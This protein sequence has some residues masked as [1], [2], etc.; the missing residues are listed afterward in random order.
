LLHKKLSWSSIVTLVSFLSACI[1]PQIAAFTPTPSPTAQNG[2][3]GSEWESIAPGLERRNYRPGSDYALTQFT[4]LRIDPNLYT[5]R[6]HYRPGEPLNAFAWRDALPDAAA[7]INANFFD[8]EGRVLGLLVS[9]GA[10]Y[11][12]AYQNMGG[13]LYVQDGVVRVRSTILEPYQGEVLEQATQAFPMLISDGEA[14]FDNTRGDRIS[15]RTI[16]AQDSEGQI[17]LM[18][19]S[20][21]IGIRLVDL[22]DYLAATDLDLVNAFNLDGGGSTMMLVKSESAGTTLIP[23]LDSVPAVLAIYPR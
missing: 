8:R 22:S 13:M 9:D 23:S 10:V 20:S 18:A 7:F 4:A 14:V 2:S 16:A 19:T 17:V 11:G 12:Q 5:F 6:V 3:I 15:R 21:L 1:Q